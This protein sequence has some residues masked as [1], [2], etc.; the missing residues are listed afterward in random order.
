M[1]D[2]IKK[3]G[4]WLLEPYYRAKLQSI[5]RPDQSAERLN[6]VWLT[7]GADRCWYYSTWRAALTDYCA[8]R[9]KFYTKHGRK[10]L[11]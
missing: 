2:L 7:D 10:G 9:S 1:I 8:D 6:C 3:L 5:L 11:E 4:R